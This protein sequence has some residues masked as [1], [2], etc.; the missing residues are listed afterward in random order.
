MCKDPAMGTRRARSPR[1]RWRCSRCRTSSR[2]S[3][4]CPTGSSAAR[5]TPT[6]A[7]STGC[8]RA[9]STAARSAPR[10]STRCCPTTRVDP[11]RRPRPSSSPASSAARRSSR[12]G[13]TRPWPPRCATRRPDARLVSICTGAFVLAAAGL[14]DGRPATTHW[15]H[16]EPFRALL[17]RGAAR[18]GRP[19]RRRRR[20]AHLRRQR[21]RDRPAAAHR[22]ARPRRRGGQPRGAAQ[23]RRAVAG[24][25]PVPVHRAARV[26]EAGPSAG[27]ARRPGAWA[28]DHLD[29]P[30]T[31]AASPAHARDERAHLHP[32]VPRGDRAEPGHAGSPRSGSSG[33]GGCWRPPTCRWTGSPPTP[34]SAPPA[35]L[36]QHL[37]AAIGVS[38]G[39]YRRMYR[40][41]HDDGPARPTVRQPGR[42]ALTGPRLGHWMP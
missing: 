33:P 17:P 39:A 23:R 15:M 42:T 30:L 27:T 18:P 35:S 40:G 12:A 8:G 9:R 37:R 7:R 36:R 29:E 26:P 5:S 21:R 14:L 20:R 25:R 13:S 1:T 19:L 32:P 3:S 34:G 38:P 2:S 22:A 4:G 31:L 28:L 11:R 24:R 6:A 41:P 10:R 16:A